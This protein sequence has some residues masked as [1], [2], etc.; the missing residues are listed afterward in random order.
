ME[1]F[2]EVD[3]FLVFYKKTDCDFVYEKSTTTFY[4]HIDQHHEFLAELYDKAIV[5]GLTLSY[6]KADLFIEKGLGMFKS[7]AAP[8]IYCS[9]DFE[10]PK[11]LWS[12]K[13]DVE[14]I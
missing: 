13:R 8:W 14:Y 5:N 2:K 3:Q 9:E 1:I 12:I 4:C 10:F 7:K 11:E 6:D